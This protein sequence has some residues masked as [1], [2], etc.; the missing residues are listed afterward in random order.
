VAN[1]SKVCL[2]PFVKYRTTYAYHI[3]NRSVIVGT[4]HSDLIL[5]VFC[6]L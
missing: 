3:V 2:D 4:C 6:Y 1:V 5:M